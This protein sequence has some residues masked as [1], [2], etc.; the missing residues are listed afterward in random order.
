MFKTF[1]K[2]SKSKNHLHIVASYSREVV[3]GGAGGAVAPPIFWWGK[4]NSD[5]ISAMTSSLQ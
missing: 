2:V 3:G 1:V 4:G 5:V